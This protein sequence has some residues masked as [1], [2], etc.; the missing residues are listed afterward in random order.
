MK[1]WLPL[2]LLLWALPARGQGGYTT[3]TATVLDPNGAPYVGCHG[4]AS[5]VPS[6]TATQAPLISGSTFQTDV[7]IPACDSFANF[8]LVLVDNNQVTDGHVS[9]PASQWNFNIVSQDG[10]TGFSCQM[11]I[12]GAT[13]NISSQIQACAAPLSA[14]AGGGGAFVVKPVPCASTMVFTLGGVAPNTASTAFTTTL[15]CNVTTTSIA[16]PT[17]GTIQVGAIA[18]FTLTQ[19]NVGGFTFAWPSNFVDQPT[20]QGNSNATTNASFWYDGTKWHA[21]TFPASGGGAANAAGV[22]GDLQRNNGSGGL[23]VAH[24]NDN[25]TALRVTEDTQFAGPNP[26]IDVRQYGVRSVATVPST[27]ANISSGTA[28]ASLASTSTF[29]NG[30]GVIIYGAGPPSTMATPSAPT[31]TPSLAAG[32]LRTTEVVSPSA[33]S[34]TYNYQIF[35][36]DFA[37]GLT[38]ASTVGSTSTGLA[39]L[40]RIAVTVTS[41]TRSNNVV[42]VVMSAPT[43]LVVGAAFWLEGVSDTTFDGAYLVATVTDSTHFTF[44]QPYD[45]RVGATT[46][47][48]GGTLSYYA[49]NRLTWAPVANAWQYYIYGRTGGTLTYLGASTPLETTFDDYGSTIMGS[50]YVPSYV[51]TN[52][53]SSAV[54]DPLVTTIVSGAGTTNLVLAASASN[55]VS[56]ATILFDDGINILTAKNA[57]GTVPLYF[58]SGGSGSYVIN[59]ATDF[60]TGSPPTIWQDG[61]ITLNETIKVQNA[62]WFANLGGSGLQGINF[63][64]DANQQVS[65]NAMP[66]VYAPANGASHLKNISFVNTN[67][68]GLNWLEDDTFPGSWFENGN[69][70]TGNPG[71]NADYLGIGWEGRGSSILEFDHITFNAAFSA[72]AN[73]GLYAPSLYERGDLSATQ[74]AGTMFMNDIRFVH[75]GMVQDLSVTISGIA[76]SIQAPYS[77][78]GRTPLFML[79]EPAS[80]CCVGGG[81]TINNAVMDTTNA[82]VIANLTNSALSLSISSILGSS[83]GYP[84][85]TGNKATITNGGATGTSA[86]VSGSYLSDTLPTV[87]GSGAFQ[88]GTTAA[89]AAPGTAVSAGGSVTNGAHLYTVQFL[90]INGSYGPQSSSST[91]TTTTGNNTVTITRPTVPAGM[92]NWVVYRDGVQ[93]PHNGNQCTNLPVGTTTWVDSASICGNSVRANTA[94][95]TMV[96]AAG[97]SSPT[98]TLI[99]NGF[100]VSPDFPSPLS[101]NRLWHAPDATGTLAFIDLAQ[102]WTATQ[103]FSNASQLRFLSTNGTNYA[104]F[105]GGASVANLVWLFPTTDS[106]GTQCLSSNGSLQLSW[107]NCSGGTGTPG[108]ATTQVQYNAAGSF[109]GSTNLTWVSPKLSIGSASG[110]TGQLGF[111]GTTSG[112]VTAQAQDAAGT[113]TFKWPTSGGTSGFPLTTDGTGVSSWSLLGLAGGGTNQTTFTA[114][115]LVTDTSGSLASLAGTLTGT[116]P[117]LTLTAGSAS[118][119]PLALNT[120]ST[121]TGDIFDLQVNGTKTSFF[122][123]GAFL[124]VPQ[125]TFN[126]GSNALVVSGTEATCPIPQVGVDILCV[127]NSATHTIQELLNGTTAKDVALFSNSGPS[128]HGVC[129]VGLAFPQLNCTSAGTLGQAFVSQG[130]SADGIFTTLG[131][132]GGGTG[133]TTNT[134]HGVGMGEGTAAMNFS[135]A[136]TAGQPFI[137]GG[138]GADGAYGALNLAG[139][140]SIFTGILPISNGGTGSSTLSAAS[141]VTVT[142]AITPGDCVKWS[143]STVVTD[144]GAA[145]GGGGGSPPLNTITAATGSNTINNGSNPQIWNSAPAGNFTFLKIG[146]SAAGTGSNNILLQTETLSSST[147]APFQADSNGKGVKVSSSGFLSS[148]STGGTDSNM[149]YCDVTTTTKCLQFVLS[150]ITAANTRSWTIQDSSDTFLGRATTDTLTNKTYDTAGTGN[151]FKINGSQVVGSALPNGVAATTQAQLDNSTKVSTTAYVD[152]AVSNAVAGVNPA[153]AVLAATAGSNLTGTYSNGVSGVGATFTI[154]ATGA[155]TLDGVAINTIGQRVLLKDQSSAFQNGVYT[156]TVVGTTGISPVFTRALDYDSSSDINSTGTIPVQSGAVNADTSWLITSTV[157]TVG[158]D[159]LTY[160]QFSLS[161]TTLVTAASNASGANQIAVSAGAN[162]AVNFVGSIPLSS[163]SALTTNWTIDNAANVAE[164]DFSGTSASSFLIGQDTVTTSG[165]GNFSSPILDLYGKYWNGTTDSKDHWTTQDIL[166]TGNGPSTSTWQLTHSGSTANLIIAFHNLLQMTNGVQLRAGTSGLTWSLV[167]GQDVGNPAGQ[168][169]SL[170]VRGGNVTSGSSTGNKAGHVWVTGGNNGG[171]STSSQAGSAEIGAGQSTGA[172]Q[173]QQGLYVAYLSY[174]KGATVTQWNLE[175]FSSA[176]TVTD[177]GASPGNWLGVAEVVGTNTIQ[178]VSEGLVPVN[179]SNSAT[180]GHTFCAGST[181][182]Q[183]TDSGGTTACALGSQIGIVADVTA[184]R[185]YTYPD[186]TS[187]TISAT[188]PLI[189]IARD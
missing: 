43:S 166:G 185:V 138:A 98:L 14:Q 19:N 63:G 126:A 58:P 184:S 79:Q 30:D 2:L 16:P 181:A 175:C 124:H 158:T 54:N 150:G 121:P 20:I 120:A 81:I 157:T 22:F 64:R 168:V 154:T 35:A 144:Q 47:A 189:Q 112:V 68:Q 53:P 45:T 57:A 23:A 17:G 117:V 170:D 148:V 123:N 161:P 131:A 31:V 5:F 122:D 73:I 128:A 91:A 115:Q 25:G 52:P 155:F 149:L 145:C 167:G 1:R 82:P 89:V 133:N 76:S 12:T 113:W 107:S 72:L 46:S 152:L 84:S 114:N 48:T 165:S 13:Q 135:S 143:A 97:L 139:G 86:A 75:K 105:Q 9:P 119:V 87:L 96:G 26:Y 24:I 108:G 28:T 44:A 93:I 78:G 136:G 74:G 33:G 99:N 66:G 106:S 132:V 164:W 103:T 71:K 85:I 95:V 36:R 109:G 18:Q 172:T 111:V 6:P 51:P 10:K 42:S 140:A 186:G 174:V 141:I 77:Q 125:I 151:V 61:P 147:A 163:T 187:V 80:P 159:S 55:T 94:G 178:V 153:I 142:G 92:V 41:E 83:S 27:T 176:M 60:T 169:G 162:K 101:A 50:P 32:A 7:P 188:L 29:Q 177:C 171:T 127:G 179:S 37:G 34:T 160:V 39:T 3:V 116:N 15:N 180:V 130:G 129:L 156:A 182:G 110:A 70:T 173:G 59:S 69:F 8:T 65:V 146:E 102:N 38:A 134:L 88:Y 118:A 21:Q 62:N 40:G 11:T 49:C 4:N 104:G 56:G 100:T 137:S 67:D 183:G 90:D